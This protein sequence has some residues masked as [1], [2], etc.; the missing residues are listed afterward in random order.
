M[1]FTLAHPAA[2]L[3]LRGLKYL[4]TAPL[5]IGAMIPDLPYYMPGRLNI[6]RPETHSVTGSLTTCLALGYAALDAVYLLRRPLT[7]LLSPRA[8][9]L[10]LRALAPFR[11]RP[12]EWA[13]AS[14]SIVI[15]VWTHL[16]WDSFTHNDGWIVR[17]VAVLS[18]PV[19]FAGYHGTVCHVLQYV[20]SAIGL[21]ALALWYG[22]LPAPRAVAAGRGAPRSPVGPA[23]VLVAAAAILIGGVQATRAFAQVPVMYR[24]IVTFL[25]HS[26]AWF[27]VLYLVAGTVVTLEHDSDAALR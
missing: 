15:G 9:F 25:T 14:V 7:A 2:I 3:P 13:L 5:V 22:R 10:C 11:G 18:A 17:R 8:R 4:R 12:L 16:L 19:S 1:P 20:T 27:A 21:G 24:T 26:L 6:L 23:L